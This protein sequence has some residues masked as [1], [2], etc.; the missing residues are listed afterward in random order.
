MTKREAFIKLLQERILILDGGMGT[1]IQGFKLSEADYR[2]ERFADFPGSLKGNNDLLCITQPEIIASIHRQYLDA[3]ADIFSTNTFNANAISMEDYGM[4]SYVREMNLAAGKLSRALVD[5]YTKEHP[6]RTVFIAGSIGPTN[7]TASMSPDVSDPAYRAVTYMDL[8]R[9]YKEQVEGLVDG[10]VDIILFETTFDTLNVKAGL[11]AADTVMKEK[12]LDLPIMLSLTLT[13]LGGRTFSGQTLAAF[14]ASVQNTNIVSVGLNC[15]FG[16]A[17]IR[18]YLE[19]LAAIAPYYIST[20]PNAGLP[21]SF[22]AYDETPEKMAGHVRPFIE[23][24]LVNIIGGCCGTTPAHIAYYPGLLK[25]S[26]PHVPVARPKSLWL[27]GL[28]LLEIKEGTP[29]VKIGERC[30]VAGSRKFLRLIKE[31]NYEEALTI[32]RKQIDDGADIIDINMDDGLLDAQKEM[33][34]FLNLIAAE[35]DISRVPVMID[36][37]KWEV[38]ENALMC[39]QGKSIVN[40]ISLKEGEEV[41]LQHAARVR[42]LGAAAVVMAFDETG[43]ADV[44]ERKIAVCERAYRLLVDKVGFNPED[45]IFDPN[46][47]AISTGMEEHNGYGL[48]FIRAVE[49]IKKNLPGAKVSGGVSNLSFSFRGN[50]FLREAMHTVFLHYAIEQGMDMGIVNPATSVR[51]GDIEPGFRTLLE[52]LILARRPE[53][54]EELTA[55]AQELQ[56]K[57]GSAGNGISPERDAWRKLPVD[58]R[59]E[60]ALIKGIGDFLETDLQEALQK[61]SRAIEIIDGPLMKGMNKVGDLFGDGKM[62]LPQVVKTARTMKKAVA[63]L[64][65]AIEAEKSAAASAKAGKM[66]FATVKGD[67][68]DIGKNIVSIVLAC[69]NYEVIDLGVMVPAEKIVQTAIKE[70]PDFV[71]LSGL[72]TPSLDEMVHVT[73]LMQEAG[74]KIPIMV[75]GATTSRL[76]TA[77]KIAPHYKSP[78]FHALDASQN[79][80]IA[81]KMLNPATKERYIAET[82]AEYER[83]RLS[84]EKKE[85]KLVSLAEARQHPQPV[86]WQSY[87]P[88]IPSQSGVQLIPS[89]PLEVIIP[90]IHWPFFFTTWKMNGKYS[91]LTNVEPS[92]SGRQAWLDEF[93]KKDREKAEQAMSLYF[94]A[95]DLLK[96]LVEEKVDFCKAVY[97]FF[98]SVSD[99]DTILIG[100]ETLP[101]LRQQSRTK[102]NF[103][104]SLADFILPKSDGR[105]D[106]L[107][108]FCVT[109]G[110]GADQWEEKFE[111][112]G[113]PYRSMLLQTVTDRLAEAA[114]EYLHMKV[115][116]EYWG[117]SRDENLS[118][119]DLF[120]C[121]YQGIRPAIGYPS[122]PDQLEIFTLDKLLNLSQIGVQLTEN[123]AMVPTATVSGLYFAHPDANYFMIGPIDE[124][125][126]KDYC[127][128][129][130]LPEEDA[131]RMLNKNI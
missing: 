43:Q 24:Q 77:L 14:L 128:R 85:V 59:L 106:Y 56:E 95:Q 41:F 2:G 112:E 121:K 3:G 114:A 47:L 67:V 73:D 129:R 87:A 61:Y 98:P 66:V 25:G 82:N 33:T 75:G 57:E 91:D 58:E 83:L 51:F 22:G 104:K 124:E 101:V 65:P 8:Y 92:E 39:V 116:R 1:M 109:A 80:L 93:P 127:A 97:G 7:K 79:P 131:R 70:K 9:A 108:A 69:N 27:S 105:T 45:I 15:S 35:P 29:F 6:E 126:L 125:Q 94:D 60:H 62:F 110:Y 74:L 13:G 72:I 4:Q 48:D 42:Q 89:I 119:P 21:N 11:E 34:T 31:G 38:I 71:C 32:A 88:L 117:Y 68:H 52:D 12:N 23:E 40:S 53:A 81:A 122:L 103:Y 96:Q 130:N 76:H 26:K 37:S 49:W 16:A 18:P 28:E 84:F 17:E 111:G 46:V 120:R 20:H 5:D 36:S 99:G 78:V 102:D 118:I 50:N 100:D 107:G 63:I 64:Q 10:G 19:E 123:G 55:Y 54:A 115:R 44:F 113:D 90:Y 86:D 30:N